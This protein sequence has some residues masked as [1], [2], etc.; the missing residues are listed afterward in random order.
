MSRKQLKKTEHAV[1][2]AEMDLEEAD[3]QASKSQGCSIAGPDQKRM[4]RRMRRA[5]KRR[6]SKAQRRRGKFMC[7]YE[8]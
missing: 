6:M 5:A 7:D 8:G 1:R 4:A 2:S 3:A